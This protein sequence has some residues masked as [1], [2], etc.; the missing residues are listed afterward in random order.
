LAALGSGVGTAAFGV[1][2][3]K[4]ASSKLGQ[5]LGLSDID[6]ML[7]RGGPQ[8]ELAGQ[9]KAGFFKSVAASGFSEGVLEELP[10]S[11]QEQMWQNWA[12][13]KPLTDGL[14]KAA[15]TGLV[16]GSLAGG[17]AG[18]F[19]NLAS[20]A[21]PTPPQAENIAGQPVPPGPEAP[22]AQ[23]ESPVV[24]TT[25]IER[26]GISSVKTVYRDG[27]VKIDGEQVTPPREEPNGPAND[28]V[29]VGGDQS[30][31]GVSVPPD[32]AAGEATDVGD[33][34]LGGTEPS[35]VPP[36]VGTGAVSSA[37]KDIE[38][39]QRHISQIEAD[40]S[41]IKYNQTEN[42]IRTSIVR[43]NLGPFGM[44]LASAKQGEG[45]TKCQ[46]GKTSAKDRC[47][48]GVFEISCQHVH[49]ST[50]K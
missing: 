4:A 10:Q 20:G 38:A 21:G 49:L 37:L 3:G 19:G 39:A 31:V 48:K 27:S 29:N 50:I 12:T 13:D 26:D 15:A 2:G 45:Q 36:D 18:G 28:A 23:T 5:R 32:T 44:N 6:T 24:A 43:I 33:G 41:L 30:G 46:S 1:L 42:V 16:V 34:A 14:G 7:V 8:A 25:T 11:V 35:A 17:A 47:L 40:P 9:A 22:P